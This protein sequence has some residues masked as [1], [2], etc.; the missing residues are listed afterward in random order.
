MGRS[1]AWTRHYRAQ[2]STTYLAET[3]RHFQIWRYTTSLRQL[4][5]R[6]TREQGHPT[7]I[8]VLFVN[9]QYVKLPTSLAGLVI[10]EPPPA[11]RNA[12]IDDCG[13]SPHVDDDVFGLHGVDYR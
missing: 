9:V 8:D 13:V 7:R 1:G 6:S 4:L 11:E 2:M 3:E 12:I 5:L 10:Y